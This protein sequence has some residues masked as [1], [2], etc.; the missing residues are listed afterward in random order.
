[1][2]DYL[3]IRFDAAEQIALDFLL[4]QYAWLK[5]DAKGYRH[6]EDVEDA[7][8]DIA[9]LARIIKYMGGDHLI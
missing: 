6:P 5:E 1:M 9:A 4:Q 8:K 7:D 2:T 3:K